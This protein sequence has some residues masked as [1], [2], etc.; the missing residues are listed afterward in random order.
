MNH[1]TAK[2]KILIMMV[3]L[4]AIFSITVFLGGLQFQIFSLPTHRLLHIIG[5]ILFLGNIIT[6]ALWMILADI[7]R[8]PEIF[9]FSIRSIN[10]ADIVFTAPGALLLLI[11]GAALSTTWGGLWSQWWLKVSLMIFATI[12]MLW[13]VALVPMQI[14]FEQYSNDI[15]E[16]SKIHSSSAAFRRWLIK[17][18]VI[19]SITVLGAI[20]IVFL[21]SLKPQ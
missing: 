20:S 3:V 21:M 5:A 13:S 7:S 2:L 1:L 9:R 8:S 15:N 6:G 18:F 10:L 16:F 4:V 12:G 19:G 14:H 11:N 17:Y